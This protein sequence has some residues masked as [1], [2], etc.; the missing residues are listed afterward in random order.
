MKS[1]FDSGKGRAV[2]I[3]VSEIPEEGFSL[4]ITAE[5]L[6]REALAG[7]LFDREPSGDAF[8]ERVGRD[9]LIRARFSAVLRLECSR[10]LESVAF[11]LD[12][13][14][15]HVVRPYDRS[16][17]SVKELELHAEDLDCGFY[18]NDVFEFNRIVEEQIVLS[19]PMKPLCRDDCRGLCPRCGANRNE[20]E[21]GCSTGERVSPF[22]KLKSLMFP[23][24]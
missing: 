12:L 17:E 19:L 24:L 18:E 9:V 20:G 1:Y 7:I 22:E 16:V 5:P 6:D 21:C 10:C 15:R 14:F 8:L 4:P 11:P 2:K 13:E 3:V 23:N